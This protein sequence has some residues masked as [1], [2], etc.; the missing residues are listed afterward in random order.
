MFYNIKLSAHVRNH[1]VEYVKEKKK[2][3]PNYK[4]LDIGGVADYTTWSHD[5]TDYMV[6]LNS[7]E[8]PRI[9]LFNFNINH[10]SQWEPLF[11]FVEE[12][13]KFDFCI[14][15]HTLED[16]ALPA[17]TLRN[18]PLIA[19]EGFVA[20]PSKFAE[21]NRIG[22]QPWLGHIHHRWIFTFKDGVYIAIPK[23]S[24]TEHITE[25]VNMGSSDENISDLNFF[26][27]DDIEFKVLNNDYM[28][29]SVQHVISYYTVLLNDDQD[30]L[31][32]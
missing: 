20:T 2:L 22:T 25:L 17:V 1:V 21:L 10:E 18:M 9:K 7:F 14:C 4:V 11:K 15:S 28:G 29:P 23:L 6:D 13:G 24:F 32:R 30:E 19:K 16:I 26:W 12:N 27:K 5:I 8:H 31:R 3:N